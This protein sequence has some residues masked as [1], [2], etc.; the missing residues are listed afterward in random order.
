[1]IFKYKVYLCFDIINHL[2]LTLNLV[3]PIMKTKIFTLIIFLAAVAFGAQ[4]QFS[5]GSGTSADPYQITTAAQ[6]AQLATLVNSGDIVYNAAH[7]KLMNNIDLNVAPYNTGEGWTP[8]GTINTGQAFNGVFDGNQKVITGLYINRT[9]G[10][11]SGLFGVLTN[12]GSVQ[13]LG[14][15]NASINASSMVGGIV[16]YFGGNGTVSHCYVTGTVNGKFSDYTQVGGIAGVVNGG[17]SITHCYSTAAVSGS[18]NMVGGI[19]GQTTWS[20]SVTHCYATGSVSGSSYVGGIAA[21]VIN[22]ATATDCAA[23]NPSVTIPSSGALGRITGRKGNDDSL[24]ANIAFENMLNQHGTTAWHTARA[25]ATGIYGE[26]ISAEAIHA[27][28][29]LGGRFTTANGWTTQNGKLPGLFGNT[30]D[31]PLHLSFTPVAPA[32]TTAALPAGKVAAAYNAA[33]AATGTAPIEWSIQSGSLPA[34]LNLAVGGIISGTPTEAGTFNF[35]VK[36]DNSAGS[37]TKDF[38]ITIEEAEVSPTITTA[39]LPDAET[40]VPYS[41]TLTATGTAPITWAL[42]GGTSVAGIQLSAAGVLSG[43][44]TMAGTFN[45]SV[46]ASN[47]AGSDTKGFSI[48]IEETSGIAE[49]E[50][51]GISLWTADAMLHI[52]LPQPEDVH[53]YN[54][55]GVLVKTLNNVQGDVNT[56]LSRGMYIVRIG[57]N[58]AKVVL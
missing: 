44:P 40:G 39:A 48:T 28:G 16:G 24:S 45:F 8:I 30:V 56:A 23:L 26:S 9:S 32:I 38:S 53:I 25:T 52:N 43:T 13:N 47:N 46:K 50:A 18:G 6:L 37:D 14:L 33:L 20:S 31:M 15:E 1:M 2:F 29:T 41:F 57:N 36:A 19:V 5:G 22:S 4:A 42:V 34:G 49:M 3:V 21:D 51:Q 10:A 27:D 17:G 11:N 55:S 12:S 7:Y 35:T 54:V 58:A